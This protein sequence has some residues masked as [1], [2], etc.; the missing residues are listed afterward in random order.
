MSKQLSE[1]ELV[2]VLNGVITHLDENGIIYMPNEFFYSFPGLS[3]D[4][5][6]FA[7]LALE[8][9]GAVYLNYEN[10][11]ECK[12]VYFI[13]LKDHAYSFLVDCE[14]RRKSHMKNWRWNIWAAVITAVFS[15]LLGATLARVSQ[16][17]WP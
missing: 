2:R 15:S 9:K 13:Q 17:I 4:D 12:N 11:P 7:L 1:K 8:G 16:F 5:V 3:D 14:D 6:L 10:I